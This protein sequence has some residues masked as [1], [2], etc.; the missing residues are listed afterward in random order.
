MHLKVDTFFLVY[1]GKSPCSSISRCQKDG[2]PVDLQAA[3]CITIKIVKRE[4]LKV[5]FECWLCFPVCPDDRPYGK[6]EN[7]ENCDSIKGS[8]QILLRGFFPLFVVLIN[9][10]K[11]WKGT[12]TFDLPFHMLWQQA[13]SWVP[14]PPR[15]HQIGFGAWR[16]AQEWCKKATWWY[17]TKRSKG[18]SQRQKNAR[19]RNQI[20]T[21][22]RRAYQR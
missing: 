16:L 14:W 10:T 19:C 6:S 1:F 17:P 5:K 9:P 21:K 8:C 15:S 20:V 2:S 7:N 13:T 12:V 3:I 22:P 18:K 4:S 11:L